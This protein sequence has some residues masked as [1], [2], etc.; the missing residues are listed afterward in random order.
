MSVNQ[1]CTYTQV[2]EEF[3]DITFGSGTAVGTSRVD[4]FCQEASAHIDSKI[5]LL[6]TTPVDATISPKSF[7]I[8]QHI[9]I[10][11][12]TKRL[13][14]ILYV[15]SPVPTQSQQTRGQVEIDPDKMLQDIVEKKSLL[16]DAVSRATDGGVTSYT[17][18]NSIPHVFDMT[19][20]Q[21]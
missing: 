3:K 5:G 19:K 17:K 16:I 8:L 1:Y 21:W 18:T 15:E 9:S 6:Y 4:R 14:P 12:V 13:K 11:L 7:L 10:A 20:R 2:Q